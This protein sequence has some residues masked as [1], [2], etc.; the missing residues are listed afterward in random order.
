MS[1]LGPFYNPVPT[2]EWYRVQNQCTYNSTISSSLFIPLLNKNVSIQTA[3]YYAKLVNKG[4]ILQYKK[5]SSNLTKNQK[6]SLIAK[7][8]WTNR[9]TTWATQSDK[10]SNP[11][12][13]NLK[14]INGENI[15][16]DG[17]PTNLPIPCP[18]N[19]PIP[20][21]DGNLPDNIIYD[22]IIPPIIIPPIIPSEDS[23]NV[24][25][26]VPEPII[27]VPTVIS[28]F[29]NLLCNVTENI[30]TG[31]TKITKANNNFN[32]S[33]SS[34]VPGPI[35]ELYWDERIQTWFPRQRYVM[36]TT[37]DKWPIN[38]KFIRPVN[39]FIAPTNNI[40]LE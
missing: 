13:L 34:D 37:T 25:P 36:N 27:A 3:Y 35:V 5:N 33:S 30:C 16:L 29:G 9:N 14:R 40:Y 28:D 21:D 23:S 39:G 7:G 26:I 22:N 18:S 11:N 17:T 31:E 20:I 38:S 1:C 15:F 8:A 10:Y 24:I 19:T 32:P 12:T 4:N 2:K 6:Y